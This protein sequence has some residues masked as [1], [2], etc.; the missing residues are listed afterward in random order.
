MFTTDGFIL[1]PDKVQ[2]IAN[3][4][5]HRNPKLQSFLGM[6]TFMQPFM[7]HMSHHTAL[8]RE[9]LNKNNIFT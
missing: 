9:L 7:P 1:D 5:T 8:L 4:S 6:I 2:G 3:M